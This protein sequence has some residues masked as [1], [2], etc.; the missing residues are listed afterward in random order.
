MTKAIRRLMERRSAVEP[1]IGHIKYEH[2]M[3]RDHLAGAAGD[4]IN[5]VL[6]AAGYDFRCLLVWLA[7]FHAF[8][9]AFTAAFAQMLRAMRDPPAALTGATSRTTKSA[10]LSTLVR[11]LGA[12]ASSAL[13]ATVRISFPLAETAIAAARFRFAPYFVL[14]RG[15]GELPETAPTI[16][17]RIAVI[18]D[19]R[20]LD[21]TQQNTV[22]A[23]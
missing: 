19:V 11:L 10:P 14:R 22:I 13:T 18:A 1:M 15:I 3:C 2:R 6:A 7:R 20:R 23:A 9:T 17:Q 4:A 16:D 5:A 8:L 12:M 21:L